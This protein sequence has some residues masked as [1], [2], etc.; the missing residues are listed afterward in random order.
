MNDGR[1]QELAG[2]FAERVAREAGGVPARQVEWVYRIALGR[3]PTADEKGI[4]TEALGRLAAEWG[5]HLGA[6]EARRWALATY[7]HTIVNSAA[8]L[9]VD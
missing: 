5:K 3:P 9:Y 1:V 6:D 7:C 2:C 4:G 8:F